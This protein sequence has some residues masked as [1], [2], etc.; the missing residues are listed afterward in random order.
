VTSPLS[1]SKL[2]ALPPDEQSARQ[3]FYGL[4]AAGL[5]FLPMTV[6][7]YRH[8]VAPQ[9][10]LTTKEFFVIFSAIYLLLFVGCSAAAQATSSR[11]RAKI[12]VVLPRSAVVLAP[13]AASSKKPEVVALARKYWFWQ[14]VGSYLSGM[15]FSWLGCI[16]SLFII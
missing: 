8:F 5:F 4:M 11:L 15:A 7:V 1:I 6:F 10:S 14:L 3:V 13:A 2:F 16:F 12:E 9:V